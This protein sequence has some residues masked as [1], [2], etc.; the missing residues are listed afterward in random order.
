[1]TQATPYAP[2]QFKINDGQQ[3]ETLA[4]LAASLVLEPGQVVVIGCRP[5]QERSLGTFLFTPAEASADQKRQ[6]LILI[7]AS[8]NQLGAIEEKHA[9]TDRPVPSTDR[10]KSSRSRS[11]R[12]KAAITNNPRNDECR[13]DRPRPRNAR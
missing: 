4:D 12:A 1:M 5:E 3:E 8:R 6:K 2:Q 7:W 9:K 11:S 13:Q 10:Q